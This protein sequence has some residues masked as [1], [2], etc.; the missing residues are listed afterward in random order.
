GYHFQGA[1]TFGAIGTASIS[2]DIHTV[3][4]ILQGHAT[5]ELTLTTAHGSVTI[6]LTGPM[7]QSF[8]PLTNQFHYQI[9]GG[10]RAYANLEGQGTLHL[11]LIG[12]NGTPG[13]AG[14]GVFGIRM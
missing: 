6:D 11:Q 14:Q 3:G 2:G 8:A 10:T 9:V 4:F 13:G 12:T 5:G 1:G 7:Q